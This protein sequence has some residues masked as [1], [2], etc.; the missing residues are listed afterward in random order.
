MC[1][2]RGLT[3]LQQVWGNRGS[4]S[5][6]HGA[7]RHGRGPDDCGGQLTR[8]HVQHPGAGQKAKFTHQHQ[9]QGEN[10]LTCREEADSKYNLFQFKEVEKWR[11]VLK[12]LHEIV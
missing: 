8:I 11:L 4:H 7:G 10:R 1:A 3:Q 2:A 9:D 12:T 6:E 5:G